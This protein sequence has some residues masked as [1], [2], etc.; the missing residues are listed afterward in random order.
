MATVALS[1][2]LSF[3]PVVGPILSVVGAAVGSYID[4]AFLLPALFP[5]EDIIGPRINEIQIQFNEEGSPHNFA[6]GTQNRTAGSIIWIGDLIEVEVT[7]SS[8]GKGGGGGRKV[9]GYEY[10]VDVAVCFAKVDGATAQIEQILADGKTVYERDPNVNVS[11][12]VTATA[13]VIPTPVSTTGSSTFSV[14]DLTSTDPAVNL[15]E[16]VPGK[17]VDV[18][19]FSNSVNNGTFFVVS[20]SFQASTGNS[21]VRL[22]NFQGV[23]EGPVAVTI[24]QT[25][26]PFQPD[27]I[28]AVEEYTGS[29]SQNPSPT[30]EAREGAGQVPAWR[31]FSY[32]VLKRLA[33]K[34]Y[35][36]RV[37]LFNV[38]FNGGTSTAVGAMYVAIGSR[39]GLSPTFFNVTDLSGLQAR[40]YTIRGVIDMA[41]AMQ[42][43]S[44]AYDVVEQEQGEGIR[45]FQ[46]RNATIIDVDPAD[47]FVQQSGSE[48]RG[49]R[50][51]EV[52]DLP[53]APF[54]DAVSVKYLDYENAFQNGSQRERAQQGGSTE[55]ELI[56]NLPI[57]FLNGGSDARAIAKRILYEAYINRQEVSLTL[58]ASYS[59]VQEN[60]VL[61]FDALGNTWNLLVKKVDRGENWILKIEAQVEVRS[62]LIQTATHES[63]AGIGTGFYEPPPVFM[64]PVTYG[65]SGSPGPGP[66]PGP[67]TPGGGPGGGVT[68][69]P[70]VLTPVS[71]WDNE[72]FFQPVTIYAADEEDGDYEEVGLV[73]LEA[74]QG[75]TRTLLGAAP[76]AIR[77]DKVNTVDVE[78]IG[79]RALSSV[80]SI[81]DAV[82]QNVMRVGP[83]KLAFMTATL[84]GT[85]QYRLS[86]LIR[87]L[88]ET[89]DEMGNH[90]QYET[91]C[92]LTDAG[93]NAGW[94]Q[95]PQTWIGKTKYIKALVG[96]LTLAEAPSHA[97]DVGFAGTLN[98]AIVNFKQMR[99]NPDGALTVKWNR[100]SSIPSRILGGPGAAPLDAAQ[101]LYEID[102]HF[103]PSSGTVIATVAVEA[104]SRFF[105][106][107][108]VSVF[109]FDFEVFQINASAG[110]NG[111]GLSSG[112]IPI[113]GV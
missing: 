30:I 10:F 5:P 61:R 80:T 4:N 8:G 44:V 28:E 90:T 74:L 92:L 103:P 63:P 43:L 51:I 3:I 49:G 101:E 35:G 66:G 52:Q 21:Q 34:N 107:A 64:D 111:R 37:P 98:R 17:E 46:R 97:L 68:K 105:G 112:V 32:F 41:K 40:G 57:A 99:S 31:G 72:E 94:F 86:N 59:H 84:I 65:T 85:N 91:V 79:G 39:G 15:G 87:G 96:G 1:V 104:P 55:N 77:V 18:S 27:E 62:A 76:N 71:L 69:A 38:I 89:R 60:D 26:T 70:G 20:S 78:V 36:N 47:L 82:S 83:E 88:D 19:G 109:P 50:P 16:I 48:R 73:L 2:G 33:L 113:P 45:L 6:L 25:L 42:P 53:D 13:A 106:A 93:A 102:F 23:S 22:Q 11:G 58:P 14:W 7:T 110:G 81:A 100:V 108:E 67:G 24:T 56:V 95:V 9:V 12:Q 54:P 75:F 29:P